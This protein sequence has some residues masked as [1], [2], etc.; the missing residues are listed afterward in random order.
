MTKREMVSL[1]DEMVDAQYM[2]A[3]LEFIDYLE[4]CRCRELAAALSLHVLRPSPRKAR[5][6]PRTPWPTVA[7]TP[8]SPYFVDAPLSLTPV[9]GGSTR[10][11]RAPRARTVFFSKSSSP[12]ESALRFCGRAVL[13]A[14]A[15]QLEELVAP[16]AAQRPGSF[17][18]A[19][20][21]VLFGAP[22]SF[23]RFASA[24][25]G[26]GAGAGAGAVDAGASEHRCGR[27]SAAAGP[28]R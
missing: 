1:M 14:A 11:R 24:S 8:H 25:R 21:G 10:R 19:L 15:K 16:R 9:L 17:A 26:A 2:D 7:R 4:A 5:A 28:R 20:E 23:L 18:L 3:K 22:Q 13:R 12:L 27:R 6:P